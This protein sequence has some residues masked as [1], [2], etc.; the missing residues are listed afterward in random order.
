MDIVEQMRC[1]LQ[2]EGSLGHKDYLRALVRM[3]IIRVQRSKGFQKAF[4]QTGTN[5]VDIP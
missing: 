4:I 2:Q 5:A 3:F 1:E